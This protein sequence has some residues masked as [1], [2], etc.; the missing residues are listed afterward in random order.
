ML[1]KSLTFRGLLEKL[2]T[3][4]IVSYTFNALLVIQCSLPLR[5]FK[6]RIALEDCFEEKKIE[7]KLKTKLGIFNQNFR[8]YIMFVLE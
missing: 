5:S 3:K 8:K 4:L 7:I 1:G 6:F 2:S